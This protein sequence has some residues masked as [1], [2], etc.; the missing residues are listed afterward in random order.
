M[1]AQKTTVMDHDTLKQ[2]VS[3][4]ETTT[5]YQVE[6]QDTGPLEEEPQLHLKTFLVLLVSPAMPLLNGAPRNHACSFRPSPCS[7]SRSYTSKYSGTMS[8]V[9]CFSIVSLFVLIQRYSSGRSE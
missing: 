1:A 6:H 5:H 2:E 9:R 8:T 7:I 3:H 4:A